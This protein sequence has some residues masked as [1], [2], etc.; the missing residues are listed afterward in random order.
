MRYLEARYGANHVVWILT[1]DAHYEGEQGERF[2][3]AG[4][5]V[6]GGRLKCCGG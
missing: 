4:R 6:F 5:T 3:R 2:K 1:G